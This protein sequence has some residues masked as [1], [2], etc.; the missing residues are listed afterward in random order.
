[1]LCIAG[2]DS[3]NFFLRI[4]VSQRAKTNKS[5]LSFASNGNI[6]PTLTLIS[7]LFQKFQQFFKVFW[8]LSKSLINR[9]TDTITKCFFLRIFCS[10]RPVTIYF[11]F[12]NRQTIFQTNQITYSLKSNT[13]KPEILKFS[14]T[15]QSS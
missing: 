9:C 4:T 14:R 1:M 3:H 10:L 11:L 12:D 15:I 5:F 7:C 2:N 13:R 8:F 6:F